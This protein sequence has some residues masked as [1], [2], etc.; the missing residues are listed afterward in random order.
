MFRPLSI[1]YLWPD[2]GLLIEAETCCNFKSNKYPKT[3]CVLTCEYLLLICILV[4]QLFVYVQFM[5][6]NPNFL[7]NPEVK[8]CILGAQ[9]SKEKG[10]YYMKYYF[11]E[12]NIQEHSWKTKV[13]FVVIY[14]SH[15]RHACNNKDWRKA[16]NVIQITQVVFTRV[17][18]GPIK[19]DR[20]I[21]QG[22]QL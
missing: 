14:I 13:L 7:Q 10:F 9:K 18:A 15:K 6:Q 1:I 19:G 22:K 11:K 3:S 17:F 8:S 2:D 16:Q 12:S 4:F 5:W 20:W 21:L